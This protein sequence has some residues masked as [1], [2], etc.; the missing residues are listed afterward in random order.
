MNLNGKFGSADP[1]L[2]QTL[3]I[4]FVSLISGCGPPKMAPI[5]TKAIPEFAYRTS[6]EGLEVA[7]D[8]WTDHNQVKKHFGMNLLSR[9]IVPFEIAFVNVGAEGGY[10]LQPELATLL[11]ETEMQR[12]NSTPGWIYG[13]YPDPLLS[14]LSPIYTIIAAGASEDAKAVSRNMESARFMDRPLYRTDSNR[15]FIFLRF[16]DIGKFSQAVAVKF[17]TKN[18]RTLQEKTIIVPLKVR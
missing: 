12:I 2:Q 7:V 16:D 18:I 5:P 1:R 13:Y 15:G 6:S 4:M 3:A 11:D 14:V 10:F 17:Q 8:A 9:G